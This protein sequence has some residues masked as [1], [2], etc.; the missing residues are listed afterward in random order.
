MNAVN[1]LGLCADPDYEQLKRQVIRLTGLAYYL[2]RDDE[3][4]SKLAGR[5][6]EVG[7]TCCGDYL[8][9]VSELHADTEVAELAI[10]LTI[11]ETSFFRH[12]EAFEALRTEVIPELIRRNCEQ[13]RLRIWCAGCAAG[14]EPYSIAILLQREY[15][16][17]LQGWDVSILGTDIN[18]HYLAQAREGHFSD[19]FFRSAPVEL[20]ASCFQRSG[21]NWSINDEYRQNVSFQYHNLA[22]HPFP[23]LLHDLFGFDLILCRNVMIYF[24]QETVRRLLKQFSESLG[25]QGWL[26]VGHAEPNVDLFQEFDAI[27]FPGAVLYRKQSAQAAPS[28]RPWTTF[29]AASNGALGA[30]AFSFAAP[31]PVNQPSPAPP[32]PARAREPTPVAKPAVSDLQAIRTQLNTGDLQAA[33]DACH[34]LLQRDRLSPQLHFYQALVAEQL[35]HHAEKEHALRRA[36]YLD[37]QFVLAHYYLGIT[38]QH[39][40]E[41]QPAERAFRNVLA[42]LAS[43]HKDETLADADGLTV[44]GLRQL[45]EMH[46]AGLRIP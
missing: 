29:D 22:R 27:N 4:S 15:A 26:L 32:P 12:F 2:G 5:M 30:G 46:L 11:G 23:S 33:Y 13:R 40:Q 18:Q 45:T 44:D 38:L 14:A 17:A 16:A 21:N 7:A 3:L 25:D 39:K 35:G 9:L 37:R 24:D 31:W 10:E 20:K 41:R 1:A 36:I 43:R 34:R 28:D 8:R 19:W 42:L 6:S